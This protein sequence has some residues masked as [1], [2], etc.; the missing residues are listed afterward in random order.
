MKIGIFTA[1]K[2]EAACFLQGDAEKTNVGQFELYS[3]R[4]G[5][6]Q[7]VL[8]CPPTVGE[9]AASA[10]CQLLISRFNVDVIL[11]FGVVGALME[12]ASIA[13]TL[14]VGSVVHYDMDVSQID[15]VPVGRYTCFDDIAVSCDDNLLN[16]ALK[17]ENLP[18]VRC[19]SADK[20]VDA[21]E[22]KTALA[23]NFG[24]EICDMESAGI[25]IACKMNNVPCL[26]VKCVSDSFTGG[27]GEYAQNAQK[28]AGGFF[29]LANRIANAL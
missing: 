11:N 28:A 25:L 4:L 23:Q 3:F 1:M 26:L 5:K 13:S 14:F 18:V 19:A 9:I 10:A 27:S 21:A 6:H 20:F 16:L 15:D 17:V 12:N 2:K 24:A 29:R 8:C 22:Q 7:A